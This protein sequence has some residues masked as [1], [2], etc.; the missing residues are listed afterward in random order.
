MIESERRW[1]GVL[2]EVEFRGGEDAGI[3]GTLVGAEFGFGKFDEEAGPFFRGEFTDIAHDGGGPVKASGKAGC[4]IG[5]GAEEFG[6]MDLELT[7]LIGVSGR[8]ATAGGAT[9]FVAEDVDTVVFPGQVED[10]VGD[11]AHHA[12]FV[13]EQAGEDRDADLLEWQRFP[14]GLARVGDDAGAER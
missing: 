6:V 9:G 13:D 7:H 3:D 4:V 14:E 12:A 2:R 8:D 1:P 5:F 11:I 10:A